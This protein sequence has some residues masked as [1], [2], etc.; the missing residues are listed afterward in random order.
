MIFLNKDSVN[1]RFLYYGKMLKYISFGLCILSLTSCSEKQLNNKSPNILVF[2][3]DDM[4]YPHTSSYGCKWINTPG[5][6]EVASEGILFNNAFTPN[7]KSAPSRACLLTGKYSWQLEDAGNHTTNWPE[8][9][10]PTFMEVLSDNGYYAAYTGKGWAPG[11]PGK[12]NGK[13]RPLTGIKYDGYMCK[14][15]AKYI[16]N[17]DYAE[18]FRY[19]IKNKPKDKPW[20]FWLG[21]KEPHRPYEFMAGLKYGAD[22]YS[23][24]D[25]PK[26][27]PDNNV[28]RTD[29]TD[30]AFEIEY[31]DSHLHKVLD[32]LEDS[33][34]LDNT[35]VIVTADN[36]MP[37]PRAKGNQYN[38][39][40]HLPLAI[41]W[42]NGIINPGRKE[43]SYV[44]FIDIAPTIYELCGV[45]NYHEFTSGKEIS[46]I[47]YKTYDK[48]RDWIVL[49]Q[50]R[51]DYGRP[52]NQGYP[53]R[54]IIED[55]FLYINNLKPY[56]W[57]AGNPETGYLNTDG[58]PSKTEIL[59]MRRNGVDEHLWDL[60][61]GKRGAEELYNIVDNP[62]CINNLAENDKYRNIKKNMRSKLYKELQR[63]NDP[64]LG[65]YGD[66][67]D[68]YPFYKESSKDYYERYISGEIKEYQTNWVNPSDY[69]DNII[70]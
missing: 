53:I 41:M 11:N 61:F 44:S 63:T 38:S 18:N 7:A 45:E 24:N 65:D 70:E 57:P 25:V 8:G 14:V 34:E 42:K 26:Y 52:K 29:F 58:S 50:E 35:V 17:E 5:F 28:V 56:L 47:F 22:P 21:T 32:I 43:N 2:I 33:G 68:E 39:A 66:I 37:F 46:D 40:V 9:K 27:L 23:V 6:D 51:H 10:Y 16:S 1:I 30:Y 3:A 48:N 62:D 20:V 49:G 64:R 69:E 13:D 60:S 55:G 36:G 4:S 19:F 15:P 67:F 59:N 12:I 31:L 54:S